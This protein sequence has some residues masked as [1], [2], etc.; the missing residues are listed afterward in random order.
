MRE[1]ISLDER[2]G[3]ADAL[4]YSTRIPVVLTLHCADG[5][6][7]KVTCFFES[8]SGQTDL[9]A[10]ILV[11]TEG[12]IREDVS[13]EEIDEYWETTTKPQWKKIICAQSLHPKFVTWEPRTLDEVCVDILNDEQI[14]RI[15]VRIIQGSDTRLN[16]V[17]PNLDIS[18]DEWDEQFRVLGEAYMVTRELGIPLIEH[19][20]MKADRHERQYALAVYLVGPLFVKQLRKAQ[21]EAEES[22]N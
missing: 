2:R 20:W 18:D 11:W 15:Y 17:D 16:E 6:V 19:C 9:D 13:E 1:E 7:R 4:R 21:K 10:A 12:K 14:I 5:A 8:M 22:G 3:A